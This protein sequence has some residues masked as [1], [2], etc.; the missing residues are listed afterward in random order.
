MSELLT[1]ISVLDARAAR[2]HEVV[3]VG[4][5]RVVADRLAA[6]V[7]REALRRWWGVLRDGGQGRSCVVAA[8]RVL[9]IVSGTYRRA[10]LG[11]VRTDGVDRVPGH[12]VGAT[13]P[14]A[15]DR[16]VLLKG[17]PGDAR[18]VVVRL[19]LA[20][21][22]LLPDVVLALRGDDAAVVSVGGWRGGHQG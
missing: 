4:L 20:G 22:V 1:R 7:L 15:F 12:G 8:V 14:A 10:L 11:A 17:E 18:L 21:V 6:G 5:G 19:R 3:A 16:C 2:D 9:R 13:R